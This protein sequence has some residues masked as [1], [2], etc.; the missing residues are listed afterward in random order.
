MDDSHS[1]RRREGYGGISAGDPLG[2]GLPSR[3]GQQPQAEADAL[4][5]EI[6]LQLLGMIQFDYPDAFAAAASKMISIFGA[7]S[8]IGLAGTLHSQGN[9]ALD[10]ASIGGPD[11]AFHFEDL[12]PPPDGNFDAPSVI[13]DVQNS[14]GGCS[15]ACLAFD[16]GASDCTLVCSEEIGEVAEPEL[17]LHTYVVTLLDTLD[18][19]I[20]WER[21]PDALAFFSIGGDPGSFFLNDVSALL[22]P[23]VP[24]LSPSILGAVAL[25]LVALGAWRLRR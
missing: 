22:V 25:G 23:S 1:G 24:A 5:L 3:Q 21:R 20:A 10:N 12:L 16:P 11:G 7:N 13:A 8:P 19:G 2:E 14:L 4:L 9:Q 6:P 17:L 15:G 18:L